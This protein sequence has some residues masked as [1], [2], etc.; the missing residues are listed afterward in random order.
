MSDGKSEQRDNINF[1]LKMKKS[2]NEIFK[3]LTE[4]Y[5]LIIRKT[6]NNIINAL[7]DNRIFKSKNARVIRSKFKIMLIVFF[8]I[9]CIV[10][11]Q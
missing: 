6:S 4:V 8:D 3:L 11:S 9:H 7:E 10:M 5:L 2:A 1:L